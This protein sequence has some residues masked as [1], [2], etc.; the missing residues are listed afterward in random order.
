MARKNPDHS[1]DVFFLDGP[2]GPL[3]C[4]DCQPADL[5]PRARLLIIPPFAEEMNRSRL[6]MRGLASALAKKGVHARIFD[7]YGTGDSAGRFID[8]D[9]SI[10]LDDLRMMIRDM[11]ALGTP[12]WLCGIRNGA[13][14]LAAALQKQGFTPAGLLLVQ[15]VVAGDPFLT[16]FLRIRV[17]QAMAQGERETTAALKSRL[18]EQ[19]IPVRVGGYDLAPA[20]AKSLCGQSLEAL[21]PPPDLPICWIETG[22]QPIDESLSL[23]RIPESWQGPNLHFSHAREEAVWAQTE[24]DGAPLLVDQ[25]ITAF[26][27]ASP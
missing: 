10:W 27:A 3:F 22:L 7:L 19:H 14:L 16:R 11:A 4:L 6:M 9:W 24:P 25:I 18:L 13:L 20:L 23:A 1:L 17:A 5:A 21:P 2:S 12:L 15:P 26:E 8:A